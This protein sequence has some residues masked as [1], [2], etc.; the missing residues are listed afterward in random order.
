MENYQLLQDRIYSIL[1]RKILSG[2]L[3]PGIIY[4]ET[5]TA[6][7]LGVSKTPVKA[8]ILRLSQ[9]DFVDIIPSRGFRLRQM[10]QEDVIET[11]HVRTA[12]EGYCAALLS[13]KRDTEEGKHTILQLKELVNELIEFTDELKNTS[14]QEELIV[15][16]LE[17]NAN[18]HRVILV[19]SCCPYFIPVRQ[20]F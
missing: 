8:A 18:F 17:N 11:Y 14:N 5:K 2:G 3:Q 4:S 13:Q 1:K 10:T 6:A 7:E 19:K 12:I 9:D 15:N 16:I 20:V